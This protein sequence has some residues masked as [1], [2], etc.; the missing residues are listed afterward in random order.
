MW[1]QLYTP[2]QGKTAPAHAG[3]V[4][5]YGVSLVSKFIIGRN[6]EKSGDLQK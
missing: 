1:L 4:V 6:L 2:T 5:G 3:Y